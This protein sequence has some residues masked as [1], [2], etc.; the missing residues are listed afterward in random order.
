MSNVGRGEQQKRVQL[1]RS[2]EEVAEA[3]MESSKTPPNQGSKII[4][5]KSLS[6]MGKT[7]VLSSMAPALK[8][9]GVTVV[10]TRR[11]QP[12][13]S[14]LPKKREGHIFVASVL[15]QELEKEAKKLRE[16]QSE[17]IVHNLQGMDKDEA[18]K[19]VTSLL[20]GRKPSPLLSAEQIT[21]YSM[22]V[23]LLVKRFLLEGVTE[24]MAFNLSAEYLFQN[25]WRYELDPT[26]YLKMP[27]PQ[28]I[29]DRKAEG[30]LF[31]RGLYE[32]L[33]RV[34]ENFEIERAKNKDIESPLFVAPE[35]VDI[36][37]TMMGGDDIEFEILAS[38]LTLQDLKRFETAFPPSGYNYGEQ[39]RIEMFGS[40][41]RKIRIESRGRLIYETEHDDHD[42]SKD[43]RRKM[44]PNSAYMLKTDHTGL[45]SATVIDAWAAESFFQQRG[46][47]YEVKN[48]L[49]GKNYRFNPATK[50]IE[51]MGEFSR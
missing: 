11:Y 43:F 9:S 19:L 32:Y 7:S 44:G 51:M 3:V 40:E 29:L 22:G 21:E 15:A 13:Y 16:M 6:G 4:L 38:G 46:I 1:N 2:Q 26:D 39:N 25:A 35:S 17:I 48:A 12:V 8:T 27:I 5:V 20:V 34:L 31:R 45:A 24:E 47:A 36:Y 41:Y 37:K 23:P 42:V 49:Y 33:P 28:A 14:A 10:E 50:H 18:E 30:T